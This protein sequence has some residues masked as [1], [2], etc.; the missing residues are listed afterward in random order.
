MN[1]P[2]LILKRASASRPSGEWNDEDFD[3]LADG[4]VVGRIFKANAAPVGTPAGPVTREERYTMRSLLMVVGLCLWI[5][6]TGAD[7]APR[8]NTGDAAAWQQDFRRCLVRKQF[9]E[10]DVVISTDEGMLELEVTLGDLSETNLSVQIDHVPLPRLEPERWPRLGP[11]GVTVIYKYGPFDSKL[12]SRGKR[13]RLSISGKPEQSVD[14][15]IGGGKEAVAFLRKCEAYWAN[16]RIA[17]NAWDDGR[18]SAK[19]GEYARAIRDFDRALQKFSREYTTKR[20]KILFERGQAKLE[21]GDKTG[22]NA[23]I[24]AAKKMR[25]WIATMPR[26][27]P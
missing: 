24:R 26:I 4:V 13:L 1:P 8:L 25:R 11:P 2:P 19:A 3:V 10:G 20:A 21:K 18:A 14:L 15:D 23:D 5:A 7:A 27:D 22:G 16:L 17:E 9:S 6:T 12:L